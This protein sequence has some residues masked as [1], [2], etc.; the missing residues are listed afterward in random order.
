MIAGIAAN[1]CN[2]GRG[3]TVSVA[4]ADPAAASPAEIVLLLP[5]VMLGV[6]GVGEG[7]L[8]TAALDAETTTDCCWVTE[9]VASPTTTRSDD[10]GTVTLFG[11]VTTPLEEVS[12]SRTPPAGA[13]PL[14]TNVADAEEPANT[15]VGDS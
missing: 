2:C 10:A 11:N 12:V 6:R 4:E 5:S 8:V 14:R 9:A 7:A 15:L 13:G 1:A 3:T